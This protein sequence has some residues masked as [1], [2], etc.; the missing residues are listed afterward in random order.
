MPENKNNIA[1]QMPYIVIIVLLV[2]IAVLAFFLGRWA[3]RPWQV[4][5]T[6][7]INQDNMVK[8]E[9]IIVTVLDDE[10]C[11]DECMTDEIISQLKKIPI[12]SVAQFNNLDF[13]SDEAKNIMKEN[14][15][16]KLPAFLFNTFNIPNQEIA[17]ALE[18]T[19]GWLYSLNIWSSY[20]PYIERSSRW[21][22][23]LTPEAKLDVMQYAHILWNP[24]AKILWLEY[25]DVDCPY[26]KMLHF[27]TQSSN[28]WTDHYEKQTLLVLKEKYGDDLSYLFQ[29][30]FGWHNWEAPEAIECIY[31]IA[32]TDAMYSAIDKWFELT[33]G[34]QIQIAEATWVDMNAFKECIDSGKN[35]DILTNSQALW[36]KHFSIT[37]TPWNVIINQET[38]EYKVIPW[39]Y[40]TQEFIDSIDALL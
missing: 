21:F 32:W 37:W 33:N 20:D 38:G 18:T 34:T 1:N 29:H 7:N 28:T 11:G 6:D 13:K 3:P 27:G 35:K 40:P 4:G 16:T 2:I 17:W 30:F 5:M 24:D 14:W 19:D 36:I 39:A 31:D 12:L 26:C 15:I 23:L 9:D 25:A 22:A 8:N 10:R